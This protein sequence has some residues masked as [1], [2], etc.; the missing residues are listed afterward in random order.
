MWFGGSEIKIPHKFSSNKNNVVIIKNNFNT[1]KNFLT[2]YPYN[3]KKITFNKNFKIIYVGSVKTNYFIK[4]ERI[5]N[6]YKKEIK[7]NFALI[8]N[9]KFWL[10]FKNKNIYEKNNIYRDLKGFLRIYIL[11]KVKKE[12]NDNLILIG[13]DMR[14]YFK[15]AHKTSNNSKYIKDLYQGNLCLD[16]GSRWGDISFYPRSIEILESGGFLLQSKQ[17]DTYKKFGHLN[18]NNT[19][20]NVD[21]LIKKLYLYKKNYKLLNESSKK[22]FDY[23]NKSSHNYNTLTEIRKISNR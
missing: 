1:S 21:D 3:I 20:N 10:K 15:D 4:S 19:F 5:W 9:K 22:I 16:F 6:N 12:F 2:L 13:D 11:K 23:Y 18:I 14:K 7:E 8:D 17:S